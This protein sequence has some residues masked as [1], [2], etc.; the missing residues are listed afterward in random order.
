MLTHR[1][2]E[3]ELLTKASE[4]AVQR[5]GEQYTSSSHSTASSKESSSSLGTV[6]SDKT[7]I[8]EQ[9]AQDCMLRGEYDQCV[10]LLIT[11]LATRKKILKKKKKEVG[12]SNCQKERDDLARTLVNFG[13]VLSRKGENQEAFVAFQE[14]LRLYEASGMDKSNPIIQE[15]EKELRKVASS[16]PAFLI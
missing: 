9:I 15:V 12:R 14:A 3:A 10:R 7:V 4:Y 11:I 16:M 6:K 1:L 13:T 2:A 5:D 8:W